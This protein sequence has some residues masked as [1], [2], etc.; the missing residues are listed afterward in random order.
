MKF[1]II[2]RYKLVNNQ[3]SKLF[4]FHVPKCGGL[5]IAHSLGVAIPHLRILGV[6]Y[7]MTDEYHNLNVINQK[8]QSANKMY[9]INLD[10]YSSFEIFQKTKKLHNKYPFISGHIPF[11]KYEISKDT[12]VFSVLRDPVSRSISNY[13][14]FKKKFQENFSLNELY[15]K[16]FLL[17]D[18][19]TSFFSSIEEPDI[20]IAIKNI[21]QINMT[22]DINQIKDL[23]AYIISL[24]KLPNMVLTK[25]NE[26]K[27]KYELTDKEMM[28]IMD[29]NK[30]DIKLYDL[31]KK[32]FF[33]FENIKKDYDCM[34]VYSI[35]TE[36]KLFNDTHS[37]IFK[38]KDLEFVTKTIS[39]I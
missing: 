16:K 7:K 14:F 9:G 35:Y 1:D 39:K 20:N 24:F 23:L 3:F 21:K 27:S 5:S 36:K 31:A 11:N 12:F 29:K 33:D 18:C 13:L 19:M 34:D 37:L 26:T 32:I 25:I 4:F 15:E 10:S 28:L 22:I 38:E 2:N 6:P 8:I 30:L 17:P